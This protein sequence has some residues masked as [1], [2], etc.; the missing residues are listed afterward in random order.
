M[1]TV[2][3]LAITVHFSHIRQKTLKP[4]NDTPSKPSSVRKPLLNVDSVTA[5]GHILEISAET[6]PGTTVMVNGERAAVIFNGSRI[7]HFVGP[8]P[9]GINVITI[10]AQDEAGGVNTKQIAITI[11]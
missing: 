2:I 10:T 11:P 4:I 7:R 9:D 1:V 3:A 8:L 6:E 5:H